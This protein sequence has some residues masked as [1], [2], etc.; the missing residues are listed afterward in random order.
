M[1]QSEALLVIDV[2]I[3]DGWLHD[4]DTA[5]LTSGQ[6]NW[7]KQKQPVARRIVQ[8]LKNWRQADKTIIFIV[9]VGTKD[10]IKKNGEAQLGTDRYGSRCL[11]CDILPR[12]YRLARFLGHKH[13]HNGE[14]FEPLF[15]KDTNDAFTNSSLMGYLKT[16]GISK[17]FLAGCNTFA[18]VLSTAEGAVRSGINVVL[19]RDCVFP[20]FKEGDN[21]RTETNWLDYVHRYLK[22][23]ELSQKVTVS[24]E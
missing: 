1:K 6:D 19:L 4:H 21:Y 12:D 14:K 10:F 23:F 5:N 22:D 15:L 13:G 9:L 2:D 7:E 24:I 8:T 17:V 3:R 11:G 16:E 18:C 20:E